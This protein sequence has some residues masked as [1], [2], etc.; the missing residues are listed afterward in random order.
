MK[1][2]VPLNDEQRRFATENHNLVYAFLHEKDLPED[3]FYDVVIFGYLQ[4]VSDYF[5]QK[6]LRQYSFST[7]AWKRMNR[8]FL[9]YIKSLSCAKRHAQ[10]VSLYAL[11]DNSGLTWEETLAVM[12]DCMAEFESELLL[13]D[14]AMR[15][16]RQQMNVLHMK[17]G[18]YGVREI[19]KKQKITIHTVKSILDDAYDVVVSVCGG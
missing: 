16:P 5:N 2:S 4:A 10:T 15:L 6:A 12:D 1:D 14:L 11:A 18:G 19:A 9:N 13:H 8:H 17:A 3:E 7:V